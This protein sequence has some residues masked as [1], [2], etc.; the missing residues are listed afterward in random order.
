MPKK[1]SFICLLLFLFLQEASSF[2]KFAQPLLVRQFPCGIVSL[3]SLQPKKDNI[4]QIEKDVFSSVQ[5]KLDY[6][7]L[8]TALEE[9]SVADYTPPWKIAVAAATTFSLLV[10]FFSSSN[11]FLST[12][13]WIATYTAANRDPLEEEDLAGPL[14]RLVG[15]RTLESYKANEPKIKALARVVVT[16]REEITQLQQRVAQLEEENKNL[17]QWK[18]QRI[19]V[20]QELPRFSLDELKFIARHHN[21]PVGGNKADLLML[22]VEKKVVHLG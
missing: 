11:V 5:E 12:I 9:P 21:L 1:H 6:Q 13:V 4:Y 7:R 20:D 8:M 19:K 3:R 14:A 18:D 17:R 2:S 16:G 10:F 15:R 22:L